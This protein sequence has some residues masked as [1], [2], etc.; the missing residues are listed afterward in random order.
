MKVH[1]LDVHIS[2]LDWRVC[3]ALQHNAVVWMWL[4]LCAR[5]HAYLTHGAIKGTLCR[6]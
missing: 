4:A 6:V 5:T 2:V 3:R 1:L